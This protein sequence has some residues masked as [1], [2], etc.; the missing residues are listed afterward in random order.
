M[1]AHKNVAHSIF[2]VVPGYTKR[3]EPQTTL[4]EL[5]Q[6][7][8]TLA[9]LQMRWV[10]GV[11][12]VIS[13]SRELFFSRTVHVWIGDSGKPGVRVGNYTIST[14]DVEEK[15]LSLWVAVYNVLKQGGPDTVY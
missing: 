11:W 2:D 14:V 15:D 4:K 3:M 5:L 9:D 8:Y 6:N 12:L 7:H 1:E 10:C 13:D